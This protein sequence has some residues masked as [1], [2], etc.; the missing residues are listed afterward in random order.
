MPSSKNDGKAR[1][2]FLHCFRHFDRVPDH[3]SRHYRD[4]QAK[5]VFQFLEDFLFVIRGDGGIDNPDIVT[6]TQKRRGDRENAQR[7]S[8]LE[9]GERRDEKDDFPGRAHAGTFRPIPVFSGRISAN[10]K[11]IC[12]S[13]VTVV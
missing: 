2:S 12:R 3:G 8:G 9:T 7:G 11:G 10:S 13:G 6:R 1:I 4:S 5:R